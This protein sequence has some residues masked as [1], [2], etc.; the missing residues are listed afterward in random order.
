MK[1]GLVPVNVGVKRVDQIIG[2]AQLAESV[3]VESAWTFEHVMVLEDYASRY[4]YNA[5]GKMGAR[6]ETNFVD[7]LIAL[8]VPFL[9]FAGLI[10]WLYWQLAHVPGG[11]PIGAL[12]RVFAKASAVVR[13]WFDISGRR[14]RR[15]LAEA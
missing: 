3:G 9:A 8:W 4:P 14:Q 12:E 11:Q 13:R 2:L 1:F 15:R 6:P 7:P 10:W 5:D